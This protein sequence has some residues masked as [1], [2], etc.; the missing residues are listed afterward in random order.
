MA[1]TRALAVT[2]H[3][4]ASAEGPGQPLRLIPGWVVVSL[5]DPATRFD[6]RLLVPA[7]DLGA[8]PLGASVQVPVAA[9]APAS[10]PVPAPEAAPA[11]A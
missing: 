8:F 11:E 7:G 5:T 4:T 3:Q 9:P 2:Q 6:T 1:W 10:P